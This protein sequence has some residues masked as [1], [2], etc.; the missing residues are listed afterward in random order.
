MI[1]KR[2]FLLLIP[3]LFVLLLFSLADNEENLNCEGK[4]ANKQ[5]CWEYLLS[6]T[7]SKKGLN[8]AFL[9]LEKLYAT[10]PAFAANCHGF[11][12][13]IGEQAY[14]EFKKGKNLDLTR[15]SYY[16]GYGFYHGFMETLIL[17]TGDFDE[18][19]KFCAWA[20]ERLGS[21]YAGGACYHGIGHGAIDGADRRAYGD[22]KALTSPALSLCHGVAQDDIYLHR[23]ASGIFNA[24]A[25][26]L[27]TGQYGLSFNREDP[28]SA[29]LTFSEFSFPI[30]KACY[31][32]MNTAIMHH[33]KGDLSSAVKYVLKIEDGRYHDHAMRALVGY[34]ANF[35]KGRE[36]YPDVL[37]TC[38]SLPGSLSASCIAGFVSGLMEHG[39]PEKE[40]LAVLD[41]CS[42]E[43]LVKNEK[44][45]CF[46]QLFATA[47]VNYDTEK[48][49]L[50]CKV[51]HE[52]YGYSCK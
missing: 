16:C 39:E 51:V 18:A 32:E 29:C 17:E 33:A 44:E 47:K 2:L 10:E 46:G 4:T 34:G 13:E 50:V 31:E 45:A 28:Y 21:D 41:F 12:H 24:V 27:F 22:I 40:Y 42:Q 35:N 7:L 3:I 48:Y 43:N 5:Q 26:A 14:Y 19:R 15:T 9:L 38:R 6:Q 1:I 11:T 49:K 37:Q 23:C 20:Q 36:K 25:I 8:Q 52:E 30:L